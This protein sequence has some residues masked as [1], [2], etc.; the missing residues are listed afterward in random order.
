MQHPGASPLVSDCDLAIVEQQP[1][2][3][4]SKASRRGCWSADD[5]SCSIM[6]LAPSNKTPYIAQISACPPP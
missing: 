6:S 4:H 3:S 1:S 2:W 5:G